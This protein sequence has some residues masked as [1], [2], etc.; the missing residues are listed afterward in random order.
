MF[1]QPGADEYKCMNL[2]PGGVERGIHTEQKSSLF[3]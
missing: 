3:T 2:K 1:L